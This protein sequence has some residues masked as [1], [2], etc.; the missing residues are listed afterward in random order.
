MALMPIIFTQAPIR[1]HQV[2]ADTQLQNEA[3]LAL[4]HAQQRKSNTDKNQFQSLF[5][6]ASINAN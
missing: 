6:T 5:T 1:K 3:R 2:F 4:A